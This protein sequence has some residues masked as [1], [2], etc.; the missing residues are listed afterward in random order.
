MHGFCWRI[1]TFRRRPQKRQCKNSLAEKLHKTVKR[2]RNKKRKFEK[3]KKLNENVKYTE[4][5]YFRRN[6]G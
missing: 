6:W 2:Q 4:L 3:E 1:S 5:S